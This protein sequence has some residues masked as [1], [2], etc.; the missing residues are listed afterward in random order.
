VIENVRKK[1]LS[2]LFGSKRKEV[3][4]GW[5]KLYN[6][7]TL[8]SCLIRSRRMRH[9]AGIREMKDECRILIGQPEGRR[10]L[11]TSSRCKWENVIEMSFIKYGE[12]CTVFMS[13]RIGTS[14]GFCEHGNVFSFHKK[15]RIFEQERDS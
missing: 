1:L 13:L 2:L 11:G 14:A 4:E 15:R 8:F 12:V 10:P 3:I 5:R 9:V 6:E 7:E